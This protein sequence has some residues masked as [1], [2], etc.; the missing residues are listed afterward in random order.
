MTLMKRDAL[1]YML[2]VVDVQRLLA[3]N[4]LQYRLLLQFGFDF[5]WGPA[6]ALYIWDLRFG[7]IFIAPS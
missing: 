3:K 2:H 1:S 7:Y 6:P 4:E 5:T